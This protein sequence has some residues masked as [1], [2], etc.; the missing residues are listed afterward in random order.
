PQLYHHTSLIHFY[1]ASLLSPVLSSLSF[2]FTAPATTAIYTLSLH[3][4]LPISPRPT[5]TR[6]FSPRYGPLAD[7]IWPGA[8]RLKAQQRAVGVS[9]TYS[10]RSS[11]ERPIPF[12]RSSGKIASRI[13]EPSAFA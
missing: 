8:D 3:D 9:T 6:P 11:G 7:S 5:T 1:F 13:D 2:L 12:G 10:V 4:A